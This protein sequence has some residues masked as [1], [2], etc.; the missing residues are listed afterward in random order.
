MQVMEHEKHMV[1]QGV[2]TITKTAN[3]T[4]LSL[5]HNTDVNGSQLIP[6]DIQKSH[7]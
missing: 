7:A 6:A 4:F 3:P 5:D 2:R 1:C